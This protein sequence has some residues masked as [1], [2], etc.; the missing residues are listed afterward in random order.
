M[1]QAPFAVWDEFHE[2][3]C[4]EA[5]LLML[6]HHEEGTTLSPELAEQELQELV[7]WETEHGYGIDIG[8]EE[9]QEIAREKFSIRAAVRTEV[10]E[11]SI[12]AALVNGHPVIIPAAGRE[13][14]NPYYSGEGPWYHAL[15]IVG[16]RTGL[17]G[18]TYFITHDPG[19]KRGE[20]YE[21]RASTLLAAVHDWP[22]QK[23]RVREGRRA[24]V[25]VEEK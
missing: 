9:M 7:A 6:K 3:T 18:H 10:T 15:V 1:V 24:M 5:V 2:E 12:K 4:E 21:Y 16:Y 11:E 23:E 25:V 20:G 22:G 13:L 14:G 17:L 8:T 19:T